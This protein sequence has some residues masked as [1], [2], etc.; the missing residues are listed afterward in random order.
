MEVKSK[1]KTLN[2]QKPLLGYPKTQNNT[3]KYL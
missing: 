2:E 1:L 3:T